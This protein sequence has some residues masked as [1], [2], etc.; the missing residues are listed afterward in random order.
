[1]FKKCAVG[2]FSL[3]I[4]LPGVTALA[5]DDGPGH[6][7]QDRLDHRGDVINDRLDRKGS[8][9]NQWLDQ[10]SD[11][12]SEHGKVGLANHL[13]RKGDRIE[14]RLDRKGNKID[15][16]LDRKGQKLNRKMHKKS[17]KIDRKMHNTGFQHG[18]SQALN[19]GKGKKKGLHR[20][21]R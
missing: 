17:Q 21:M 8:N 10:K 18:M 13:D 6:K 15:R 19:N 9:A 2:I 1:M 20:K 3:L 4:L 14:N 7:I 11:W 12:A 5:Y 16:K